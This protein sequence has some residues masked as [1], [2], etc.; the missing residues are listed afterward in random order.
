MSFLAGMTGGERP[1]RGRTTGPTQ[2]KVEH[3]A[4]ADDPTGSRMDE[5][6]REL[7]FEV[8]SVP[9]GFWR[10][11]RC[12]ASAEERRRREKTAPTAHAAVAAGRSHRVGSGVSSRLVA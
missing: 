12:S 10:R 11:G 3:H 2:T 1:R 9:R 8:R 6:S 4:R 7:R 5:A